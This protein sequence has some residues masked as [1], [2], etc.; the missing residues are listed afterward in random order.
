MRLSGKGVKRLN[1]A[2]YGDQYIHI[3]VTVPS[4][5]NAE[6]RS[7]MLAWAATEK[8]KS[9]TVNGLEEYSA[10]FA[11]HSKQQQQGGESKN[12]KSEDNQSPKGSD[13]YNSRNNTKEHS[14]EQQNEIKTKKH[15]ASS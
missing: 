7:L 9:G 5:L 10:K 1:S 6:Q 12:K 8:T 14:S 4:H 2:G 11:G 15:S 13:S 3:K